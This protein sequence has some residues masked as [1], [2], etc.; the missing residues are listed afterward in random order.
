M[1][2]WQTGLPYLPR[3]ADL[4]SVLLITLEADQALGIRSSPKNSFSVIGT[5]QVG[6]PVEA[7]LAGALR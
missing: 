5:S 3:L 2:C 7:K 4:P 6:Y 1:A